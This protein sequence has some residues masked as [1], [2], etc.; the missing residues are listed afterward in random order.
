MKKIIIIFL[1]VVMVINIFGDDNSINNRILKINM[2]LDS[3]F[4]LK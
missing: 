4:L 2:E 1:F 3:D